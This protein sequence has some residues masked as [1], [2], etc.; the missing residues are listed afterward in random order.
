MSAINPQV[1]VIG[2]IGID[3]NVYLL[4]YA[5]DL[6]HEAIFTENLDTVGQAGGYAS[7]GHARL[8]ALTAF[9]GYVGADW[10]G[11]QFTRIAYPAYWHYDI[12]AGLRVM[13]AVDMINDPRCK[14]ALDL[15]ESK[16]L[17]DGGFAAE[18]KYYKVVDVVPKG[19]GFSLVDW[20]GTSKRRS[21]EFVTVHALAVLKK[22]GRWTD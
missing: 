14:A 12:L 6:L 2:N 17:P 19:S 8:G 7:R 22:A 15:L 16:Q 20:G 13:A 4:G 21:N 10:M 18:V 3:T 1:V 5:I 9:I 11:E